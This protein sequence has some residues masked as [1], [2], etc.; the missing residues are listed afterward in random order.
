MPIVSGSNGVLLDILKRKEKEINKGQVFGA[1]TP[2][3]ADATRKAI[4]RV[5]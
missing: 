4:C 1:I 5:K 2:D 3:F